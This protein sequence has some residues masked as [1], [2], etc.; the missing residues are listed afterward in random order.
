MIKIEFT[1]G[2]PFTPYFVR[3]IPARGNVGERSGIPSDLLLEAICGLP[4]YNPGKRAVRVEIG[5]D[6]SQGFL[7]KAKKLFDFYSKSEQ[8]NTE[9][10]RNS[11]L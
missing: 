10:H 6:Y 9:V 7:D 11:R 3:Y 8:V 1:A 2:P 4:K 5:K